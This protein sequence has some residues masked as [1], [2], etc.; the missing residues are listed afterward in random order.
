MGSPASFITVVGQFTAL[1]TIHAELGNAMGAP[2]GALYGLFDDRQGAFI[3]HFTKDI[4]VAQTKDIC[5]IGR[6]RTIKRI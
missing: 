6:A 1:A 2:I 3:S 4:Y 5:T